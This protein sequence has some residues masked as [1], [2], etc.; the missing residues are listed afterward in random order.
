MVITKP[1]FIKF[2]R[3]NITTATYLFGCDGTSTTRLNAYLNS[4]GYW[5]YGNY[6]SIFNTRTTSLYEAA[7]T[8]GKI[9]VNNAI[10][11]FLQILSPPAHNEPWWIYDIGN[12]AGYRGY[13]YYFKVIIDELLVAD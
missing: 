5:R 10:A 7:I 8:P 13:I 12:T 4:N 3:T 11:E 6:G 1:K 2:K 9:T